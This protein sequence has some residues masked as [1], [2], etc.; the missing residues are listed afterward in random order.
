MMKLTW[1]LVFV[2]IGVGLKWSG[3][4]PILVFLTSAL[5]IVPLAGLMGDAT[6]ALAA[7]LGPTVGGLLNATLGNAPEI[8]IAS[9]ALHAGLVEMVKSSLTG[10]IVGNLLFGLGLAFVAGGIKLGRDQRFDPHAARMTTALL[11]IASF[12]LIIPAV[13]QFNSWAARSISRECA[14]VL[15]LIYLASLVAILAKQKSLIGKEGAKAH[16]KEN[17]E[18]PDEVTEGPPGGWSR[19]KALLVLAAVTAC[20]AVMSE[21]L[22]GAIEPAAESLHLTPRF[23]GLFLLALVGNAAEL[24]SAIRFAR[25]DQMDLCIGV[26][27]GAS[28][29]VALLVAPVLVFLG[30]IMGKDMN[31]IFSPLEL[32]AIVMAIY[33]TRNLTYDGESSWLE[34]LMLIGV[35]VL[36][37]IAFFHQPAAEPPNPLIPPLP[38]VARP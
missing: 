10:S 18:R 27:V 8:I 6:E 32:V 19:K 4:S 13:S 24:L 15:F 11:T 7:F 37:G 34:G 23:A 26:T 5:A 1:L 22:T 2:P 25:K 9:F 29:Q 30:M 14:V 28:A 21:V 38:A 16:L 33:L 17:A 36:F 35:Y 12:G 3:A 20:L 31:L